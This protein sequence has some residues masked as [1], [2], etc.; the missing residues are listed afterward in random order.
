ME[1]LEKRLAPAGIVT[2]I[3]SGGVLKVTGD[4]LDNAVSLQEIAPSIFRLIGT[5]DTLI[6]LNGAAG[7][8][9]VDVE[10]V[11]KGLTIDL[12]EGSDSLVLKD[13]FFDGN[14][15]AQLGGGDNMVTLLNLDL[16]G[17]LVIN[18]LKGND[19]I[20]AYDTTL[21]VAGQTTLNLGEGYNFLGISTSTPVMFGKGFAYAGGTGQEDI[22]VQTPF[23]LIGGALDLKLGAG[24]SFTDF[25]CPR[26]D[27]QGAVSVTFLD[28]KDTDGAFGLTGDAVTIGGSVTIKHGAGNS[29][30]SIVGSQFL[31][32]GGSV[33]I[34]N[35]NTSGGTANRLESPA[36]TVGGNLTITNGNGPSDNSILGGIVIGGKLAV[37]NGNGD[38]ATLIGGDSVQ[39]GESIVVTNK[40]GR[41]DV[42]ISA[43]EVHV[44]AGITISNFGMGSAGTP[45]MSTVTVKGT[46]SLHSGSITITNG[47]GNFTNE[48][49]SEAGFIGA[50]ITI[51]NGNT[52]PPDPIVGAADT[53]NTIAGSFH[54]GGGIAI[55][56]G[57][58][59]FY[60]IIADGTDPGGLFMGAGIAITNGSATLGQSNSI[61]VDV[62]T[63]KG[64]LAIKNGNGG[65]HY[66]TI[67]VESLFVG[68]A[69]NISNGNTPGVNDLTSNIINATDTAHLSSLI[70]KNAGNQVINEVA[71]PSLIIHGSVAINGSNRIFG[72]TR[73]KITGADVRIGGLAT[74]LTAS[75]STTNEI[76]GDRVT[77]GSGLNLTH[78]S[79]NDAVTIQG[80]TLIINGGV[81]ARLGAGSITAM[82]GGEDTVSMTILGSINFTSLEGNDLVNII[83]DG[84]ITGV[85]TASFGVSDTVGLGVGG[86]ESGGLPSL[87]VSGAV[88][89]SASASAQRI[90]ALS[91]GSFGAV[92]FTGGTSHDNVTFGG[93]VMRGAV[94]LDLLSGIDVV[95]I[96]DSTLRGALTILTGAGAD[97]VVIE[98]STYAP[99]GSQFLGAANIQLGDDNDN[100][101]IV[102]TSS[103][104]Q[105]ATFLSAV[106]LDGGSKAGDTNTLT[107]GA[108]A[109]FAVTPTIG[110]FAE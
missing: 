16:G 75:G 25:I 10:N 88:T 108:A 60:N 66:N 20:G 8:A 64:G 98:A 29:G 27:I 58:G 103:P 12:K 45:N 109:T 7:V 72:D 57:N 18:A 52:A 21:K 41:Y 39:V 15:T 48:I 55:T 100:L 62:L 99:G 104:K 3:L 79:G 85:V 35:G 87:N 107:I 24:T 68:G 95:T 94:R 81:N 110:Y 61:T 63:V 76:I 50:G 90:F 80:D 71:S 17:N 67:D 19:T 91:Y 40:A 49:D 97:N 38:G 59:N 43:P 11:I 33:S 89:L 28:H 96:D 9:S 6:R 56:N 2:A 105:S 65:G 86:R 93:A 84:R 36:F 83:G 44:G 53:I 4:G 78:G 34:T 26:I 31:S 54:L 70:I 101:T 5:E 42:T 51:K 73:N 92:N 37:T 74:F 47:I 1:L 14:V 77:L 32:I 102:Q 30:N 69:I 106:I 22:N 46:A 13:I 82:I 23:L